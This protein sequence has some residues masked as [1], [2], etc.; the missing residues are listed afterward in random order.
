MAATL[1]TACIQA[2]RLIKPMREDKLSP[3]RLVATRKQTLSG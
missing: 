3:K 1:S 2:S